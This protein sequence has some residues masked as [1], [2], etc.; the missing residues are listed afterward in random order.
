MNLLTPVRPVLT[1]LLLGAVV[2]GCATPSVEPI[3]L[4]G[5][6]DLSLPWVEASVADMGGDEDM[7]ELGLERAREN[8]RLR[9]LLVVKDGRL[10]VE[11]YFGRSDA[12]DL[13]DV[14]SVTKSVVS[15]LTGVVLARGHLSHLDEP[16]GPHLLPLVPDL[17]PAKG[18]ITVR[19]LLTMTSGLEWDETGGF[20]SYVEWIRADDPLRFVLERPFVAEPGTLYNYNSGAVHVLGVVLE[21]ASG[22]ELPELGRTALF[23]PAGITRSRWEPIGDH[24]NGGSG[25]DLTARD[26]ARFGQLYLQLG[27]SGERRVLQTD[28]VESSLAGAFS[29]RTDLGSLG[30]ITYGQLWWIVPGATGPMMSFAWGY[31]GQFVVVVHD[32]RLVVVATNNWVGASRDGGARRYEEM[33]MDVI[34]E[35]IIPA[36]R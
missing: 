30:G 1:W 16:I 22:L 20:G 35:Y 34:V 4:P 32:L 17:E 13:H 27:A 23:E 14:R 11:E 24:H 26:L 28:W 5:N 31:G 29:W 33:T 2:G 3:E 18:A 12:G 19:Q 10:V 25:I 21:Q 15:A 9:S 8:H 6:V 36:F 7:V